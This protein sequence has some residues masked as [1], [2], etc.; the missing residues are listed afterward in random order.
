LISVLLLGLLL[1][2]GG[3]E[4]Q[5]PA[6]LPVVKMDIGNRKFVIEVARSPAE[7]EKGLMKRDSM[8]DDH[9]MIF[10]F[11]R[12][13]VRKFWMKNT[14]FPLDIVFLDGKGKVVSIHQMQAY[15]I[16][17]T[18]SDVP[19]RYAVELNKGM[20]SDSGVK[21]GDMIDIPPPAVSSN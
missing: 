1:L 3:C 10:V 21:I 19:A 4:E 20:A 5:S 17:E 11:T 8:P 14:R 18:S 16:N 2:A 7:Q 6:G 15:D 13:E 9:G 12:D